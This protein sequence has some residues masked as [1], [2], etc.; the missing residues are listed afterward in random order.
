MKKKVIKY[1]LI[2]FILIASLTFS[3]CLG[4]KYSD[5]TNPHEYLEF[6]LLEDDTY[7]VNGFS[8]LSVENLVIPSTHKNK[9]VTVIKDHSFQMKRGIWGGKYSLPIKSLIIEEGIL[10]IGDLAFYE[11][12]LETVTLASTIQHIGAEAFAYNPSNFSLPKDINYIGEGAFFS[13]GLSG[14]IILDNVTV[15]EFAFGNTSVTS[16][17]FK[18]GFSEIPISIFH[19]CSSLVSVVFPDNLKIIGDKAFSDCFNLKEI[20]LPDSLEE[21]GELSF[22]NTGLEN[23]EIKD[24]VFVKRG[25]FKDNTELKHITFIGVSTTFEDDSFGDCI[26][27]SSI[28]F[29][30][31]AYINPAAFRNSSIENL[32]V[33]SESKYDVINKA[34]ALEINE[35]KKLIIGS[36]DFSDFDAFSSI[37]SYAFSGRSFSNL[38]V[39]NNIIQIDPY[40][41]S[42]SSITDATINSDIISENAF[43]YSSLESLRISSRI[44]EQNSFYYA[45]KFKTLYLD[46]GCEEI[47]SKAFVCCFELEELYLPSSLKLIDT[48]AFL[49]CHGLKKVYYALEDGEPADMYAGSFIIYISNM[50]DSNSRLNVKINDDF[51]IYVNQ[52]VYESC[53]FT[54]SDM[55]NDEL[56]IYT[57]NLKDFVKIK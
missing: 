52:E 17:V 14:K 40:A 55:P 36:S 41:F 1:I 16:V 35:E 7:Q 8:G 15:K 22:S 56:Y 53:I 19:S 46:E 54:W 43:Y 57:D 3:S 18:N 45:S 11:I 9:P 27:L 28:D 6:E 39:P 23:L 51:V 37:G 44:I 42:F 12:E 24:Y 47:G 2:L 31:L 48:G 4:R 26:N 33:A 50:V 20:N 49:Q 21:I 32:S 10:K 30:N 5:S 25:A 13:T 38:I 34:L 29:G